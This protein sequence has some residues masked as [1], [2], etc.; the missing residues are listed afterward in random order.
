MREK[1]ANDLFAAAIGV[2]LFIFLRFFFFMMERRYF[3]TSRVTILRHI[4]KE[5]RRGRYLLHEKEISG[6][7]LLATVVRELIQV[8]RHLDNVV[9]SQRDEIDKFHELY[10]SI[11]FSISSYFIVMD[12]ENRIVFANEGFCKKFHLNMDDIQGK[13]IEEIFYFVNARLKGGITRAKAE[14]ISVVLEKTHLLSVNKVSIIADIKI[15]N[16]YIQ[17]RSQIIVIIDDVTNRLRK[18]Y[19]ISL[20]SQISESI[21]SDVEIERVLYTILT[22]VTSGSGLGFNRAMLFLVDE[23]ANVMAGKMAVGPDSFE[24]AIE[25][26][27]SAPTSGLVF[28]K[29]QMLNIESGKKLL[30]KVLKTIYPLDADNLFIKALMKKE[31]QHIYDSYHDDRVSED[32]RELM[33][34]KEFVAVPIIA[35]NKTIGLIVVDNKFNQVPIGNDSIELL[36][37]FASQAALSIES[38]N[39]LISVKKEMGKI[40]RRQDAIVESEKMAAVGR[41]AAHIAHEIRN[42][43][44]TMG[45]YARRIVQQARDIPRDAG[46][47][48]ENIKKSGAIILKESERL[49]KILSNVMDFTRPSKY[50][51]EFNNINDVVEDTVELLRN[52][53]L[54]KR[55]EVSIIKDENAPLVKSDFNQM[56]QVM[57]NLI[58]NSIDATPSGG[59]ISVI[60]EY[61]REF[62]TIRVLDNG[63]GIAEEDPNIVF[64]PFFTTKVTG[65]G[66]GLANVKKIIKDHSGTIEVRNR[67]EAGVEFIVRLP[68]PT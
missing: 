10:N 21:Q 29:D 13:N 57:L 68:V 26:W 61:D 54:E 59:N 35:V 9:A 34:V 65:V 18:D 24:E 41:I 30:E 16:I 44:V 50:I 33:D 7:D 47:V 51:K 2:A 40:A 36:T 64:E 42:P 45:G 11:V 60:T 31:S 23:T 25:I 39:N 8:G 32:I 4:M 17:G 56:K 49:E 53:F 27:S 46:K 66:L 12:E 22:G 1:I 55:I 5:F 37:I 19:Q 58:Q 48:A 3:Y 20:M 43:L 52:L 38:Y 28:D 67:E 62:L 14:K 15:S 6:G 63:S